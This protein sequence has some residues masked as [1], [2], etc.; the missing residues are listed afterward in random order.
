[1]GDIAP[2]FVEERAS[3]L[4]GVGRRLVQSARYAAGDEARGE[5]RRPK[6]ETDYSTRHRSR[7]RVVPDGVR[8]VVNVQ[9]MAREGSADDDATVAVALDEHEP[10]AVPPGCCEQQRAP[11]PRAA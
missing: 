1:L 7:G 4:G 2:E 10:L 5:A 8:H 3:L 11:T 9:V 6:G